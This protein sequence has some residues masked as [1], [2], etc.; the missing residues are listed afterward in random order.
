[1]KRMLVVLALAVAAV[2]PATAAAATPSAQSD[3]T[4]VEVAASDAR[5]STLVS[6][7]QQA[8]LADTLSSGTLTVFA[9]TNRA[10]AKVPK[11]TLEALAA[12]P[13][14]LRAVLTYHVAEGRLPASRVVE[15][16]R[17]ETVNGA[18]IRVSVRGRRVFLN[19]S[20]RVTQTDIPA[21]NGIVH[22]I[23]RVLLPPGS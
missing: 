19:R 1:M 12:D 3:Q 18:A 10:F 5:F 4:I 16:R 14:K 17:I 6:L 22:A 23:N 20:A 9:P 13:A 15:R 11:R 2:V 7:V 8:G 21:S